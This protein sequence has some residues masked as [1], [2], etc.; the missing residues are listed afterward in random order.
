MAVPLKLFQSIFLSATVWLVPLI[1]F[2]INRNAVAA[3]QVR[4]I[5][6]NHNL[7]VRKHVSC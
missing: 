5:S 3:E 7:H 1:T 4:I 2:R 6:Y